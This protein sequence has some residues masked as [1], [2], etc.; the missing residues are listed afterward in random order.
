MKEII[1][2]ETFWRWLL[3]AALI[4][5]VIPLLWIAVYNHSSADDYSY[6][7]L[8]RWAWTDTHNL[9]RVFAAAGEKIKNTYLNWQGSYSAVALF[10]LQPS[11]WGEEFY[12]CT[13][14]IVLGLLLFGTLFFCRR[15]V[16]ILG[17]KRITGDLIA[18]VLTLLSIELLP[19]PVAGFFWWNGSVYYVVFYALF[20]IET[21]LLM[22]VVQK[23]QCRAGKLAVLCILGAFLAGGNYITA[24]LAMET[25]FL[26]LLGAVLRKR[27]AVWKIGIVYLLTV[28]GFLVNCLAPGNA[29]RQSAFESWSPVRAVLYS[30]HEAYNYMIEWSQPLVLLGLVFLIPF[31]WKLPSLLPTH[32]KSMWGYLIALAVQYSLFAST[33]APTLY[34]Y[35]A[36]GAGR[37]QN[38]R[39]FFWLLSCV[40]MEYIVICMIRQALP[41]A[42]EAVGG[43]YAGI[44]FGCILAL[45]A[46]FAGN[47]LLA[48]DTRDLVSVTAVKS[49]ISGEAK[50]Y[51]MEMKQRQQAYLSDTAQVQVSPLTAKPELLF[52]EDI[53]DNPDEWINQVVARFYRKDEVYLEEDAHDTI[54]WIK[55]WN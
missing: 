31:V 39:F 14:V 46:F 25:G 32:K 44:F 38:V 43:E 47:T 40:I 13:T 19:S 26:L 7:C 1:K 24:L 49:L 3:I 33:F 18:L 34:A 45:G 16:T 55:E 28:T 9:F 30:Y 6:G 20:L 23:D 54:P 53:T 48:D 29:V 36:V 52:W 22:E 51:D 50:T 11:V 21:S 12:G 4:I 17:G 10:A 42:S 41:E 15:M 5:C 2:K 27:K 37:I 8:A 35:G